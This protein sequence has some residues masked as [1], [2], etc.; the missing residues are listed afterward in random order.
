MKNGAKRN[1]PEVV[2]VTGASAGVGRATVRA[3]AKRGAYI[4]LLARGEEGLEAT[5]AEVERYGG[6]AL[7]LPTDVSDAEA[8]AQAAQAVEDAFGPIDI[9]VNDAFASIFA[10]LKEIDPKDYQRA[11]EVTY[12]GSVYGTMAALKTHVAPGPRPHHSGGLG[13]GGAERPAPVG[14]LRSQKRDHGLFRLAALRADPRQEQRQ[15]YGGADAC[16]K[17]PAVW[18]GQKQTAAQGATGAAHLS[19]R[20]GG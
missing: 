5:R 17:H 9:W 20:G 11:T 15:N 16:P 14:L 2:V 10:P 13:A 18:L 1:K 4:G 19:T 3:F 7:V 12:L 6:K 8:V